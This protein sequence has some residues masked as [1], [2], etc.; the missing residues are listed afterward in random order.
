[1][2]YHPLTE[3]IKSLLLENNYWFEDFEHEAVR[4]SEEAAKVRTGY[5]L[6]Q[7]AKALIVR[8]KINGEK[9]YVMLVVPGDVKFDKKKVQEALHAKD[10]RF[11]TEEEVSQITEGV[12][13]GGGSAIW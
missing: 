11:A 4:T 3:K 8:I 5:S 6:K 13:V 12:K 9:K 7:G 10:M 2:N 1:M